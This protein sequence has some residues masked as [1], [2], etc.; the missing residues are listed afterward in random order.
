MKIVDLTRPLGPGSRVYP[1]DP[2]FR[3]RTVA[4]LESDG[5]Y[6]REV[7][8][9]EHASTH[10]DAPA[11]MVQGGATAEELPLE[12]LVAPAVV[13][14][15]A[16]ACGP[17]TPREL[18][19]AARRRRAELPG[20]GWWLLL[21]IGGGCRTVAV[22]TA[23]WIAGN[24]LAGLGVDA[25]SPDEEPYPVHRVLLP[26]GV[27]ILE[28]LDIPAWLDGQTVTLIAAPLPLEGGS[29]APARVY[30]LLDNGELGK[31]LLAA[32][33]ANPSS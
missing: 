4:T 11:H 32:S 33:T 6:N 20:R 29:G 3:A 26:A 21:R 8:M 31:K 22:E 10:I 18:V 30:A 25:P 19:L 2:P 13:L 17:V 14:D 15:L 5:Y 1:G 7:C 16:N 27:L 28:N 12:K 23:E 24:G 9:S